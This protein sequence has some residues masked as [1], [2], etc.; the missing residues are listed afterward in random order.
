MIFD[1]LN[2]KTL[3][4]FPVEIWLIIK[5][6]YIRNYLKENLLF[7][8]L[9]TRRIHH[10]FFADYFQVYMRDHRWDVEIANMSQSS[11]VSHHFK[12]KRISIEWSGIN[13]MIRERVF[14]MG[15]NINQLFLESIFLDED[16]Q[17]FLPS[18]DLNNSDEDD[19]NDYLFYY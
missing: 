19:E 5:K 7:P 8:F 14:G 13:M 11:L 12:G 17:E 6:I 1:D 15:F 4:I 10:E 18:I 2:L 9:I 16:F 3:K